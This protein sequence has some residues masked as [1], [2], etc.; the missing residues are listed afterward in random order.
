MNYFGIVPNPEQEFIIDRGVDFY[1][2]SSE[3]VFQYD[4]GPGTGKSVVMYCIAMRLIEEGL[5]TPND[6]I[7]AAYTG[8]AA[9]VMRTKGFPMARTIHSWF[10]EPKK[11]PVRKDDGTVLMNTRY[12]TPVTDID[13]IPRSVYGKKAIFIDEG[14]MVPLSM[15]KDIEASGIK[16]F[17]GGDQGQLPPVNSEPAYLVSGKIYHLTQIMRQAENSGIVYIANRCLKGLPIHKGFYGNALV[18]GYDDITDEMIEKSRVIICGKNKTR[19][20]MNERVRR[21]ILGIKADMPMFGERVIC[22]KNNWF[23]DVDGISLANGLTGNCT[24][25]PTIS[26]YNG[27]T[28]KMGFTPDLINSEFSNLTCNYK[29][30]N[31]PYYLKNDI[32]SDRFEIGEMFE[33]AYA[34]TTHLS[35]GAEYPNGMYISE[36]MYDDSNF[37]ALN[38]TGATRFRNGL[39]YVLPK[40]RKYYRGHSF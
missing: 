34:L 39:I 6:I 26:T 40:E 11:M 29:Y 25:P 17:V 13:F 5:I 21:D 4:G 20:I 35:Q 30:Y 32:K 16:I 38:N 3:Q 7:A 22:R 10:Y 27:E 15:K 8:Q 19:D 12:D 14:Y 2:Y 28:F 18:I 9:I 33:P 1:K 23:V 24:T 36:H 31:A 37:N